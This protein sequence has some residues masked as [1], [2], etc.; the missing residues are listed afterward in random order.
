MVYAV[1]DINVLVSA[2][3]A[4]HPDSASV[5][6]WHMI[7]DGA[8]IPLYNAE[9]VEEYRNVLG[10]PKFHFKAELVD[11]FL[12]VILLK[13][14]PWK[15]ANL[16]VL[17]AEETSSTPLL[18]FPGLPNLQF[19]RFLS[20]WTPLWSSRPTFLAFFVGVDVLPGLVG[21]EMCVGGRFGCRRGNKRCRVAG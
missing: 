10:R 1:I 14:L 18:S 2:V 15:D 12:D 17:T 20:G 11:A 5:I 7:A 19:S 6:V 4:V 8:I 13:G 3:F 16:P 9:I 21:G